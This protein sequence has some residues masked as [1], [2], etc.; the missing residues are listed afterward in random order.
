MTP[1]EMFGKEFSMETAD[2]AAF[3]ALMK[4]QQE[5]GTRPDADA[6]A[7]RIAAAHERRKLLAVRVRRLLTARVPAPNTISTTTLADALLALPSS[8]KLTDAQAKA[9]VTMFADL[10]TMAS[11]ELSDCASKGLPRQ[12]RMFL[13]KATRP[14]LWQAPAVID[15]IVGPPAPLA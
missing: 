5:H 10:K 9:R 12:H 11:G 3:D 14:W 4:H 6:V 2:T 13:G 8:G 15:A 7:E 1:S